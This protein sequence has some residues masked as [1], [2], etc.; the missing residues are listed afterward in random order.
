M[1]TQTQ[2][3]NGRALIWATCLALG[4]S[5]VVAATGIAYRG[6][7]GSLTYPRFTDDSEAGKLMASELVGAE[8]PS[9]GQVKP[10]WRA[11]TDNKCKK[12]PESFNF[13]SAT[14]ES[15]G[16]AVCRAIVLSHCGEAV[17]VPE[18]LL[19]AVPD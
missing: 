8:R 5:P 19:S 7:H 18:E 16:V 6:D 11:V 3:L 9:K 12:R 2:A 13:V 14:G 17:D 15:L 4:H 10:M 1:N